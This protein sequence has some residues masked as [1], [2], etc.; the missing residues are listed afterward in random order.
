MK[1]KEPRDVQLVRQVLIAHEHWRLK[2]LRA[3]ALILNEHATSY[4]EEIDERLHQLIDGGPWSAWRAQPGGVFLLHADA[5]PEVDRVLLQVVAQAVLSGDRGTLQQQLDRSQ[6]EPQLPMGAPMGLPMG[7]VH[8]DPVRGAGESQAQP[9]APP[10][11]M[12]NGLGGFTHDG[13]EYVVVLEGDR[14]TPLPWVNILA[15]PRFGSIVTTSGATHTWSENSRDNRLTPFA[16]DPVTDPTS[17]AIFVRDEESGA[18]WGATPAPLERT[19]RSPRWVVRHAAGVTRF[20]HSTRGVAQELAVFVARDAPVKLSLLT[21]TNH[22]N[23]PRRLS[24]FSYNEWLLGPPTAT[25][26][27]FVKTELDAESGAVLARDLYG[28]ERERVAFAATSEPLL[29]ATGTVWRFSAATARCR[30]RPRSDRHG[31]ATA[32]APGSTPAP[33]CRRRSISSPARRGASC[34]C[35]ARAGMP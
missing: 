31:S 16:S 26:P 10:L 18:H 35:S 13:G 30:V 33:R 24:L 8:A 7:S 27:R 28:P 2:G 19:P 6:P 34:S 23:R 4:R 22:S 9:E 21:L 25:G 29:S 5:V 17:E 3:D 14:E 15:N 20:A 32:S 12:G 11:V 1:V